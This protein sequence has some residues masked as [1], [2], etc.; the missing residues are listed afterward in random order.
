MSTAPYVAPDTIV[1]ARL[2]ARASAD[3]R[4]RCGLAEPLP[5]REGHGGE[6]GGSPC[7]E[8]ATREQWAGDS[9]LPLD[10]FSDHLRRV[11]PDQGTG[12][13]VV[14]HDRSGRDDRPVADG[15]ALQDGRPRPYPDAVTDGDGRRCSASVDSVVV[16]VGDEDIPGDRTLLANCD[17]VLAG[18]L[19]APVHVCTVPDADDGSRA[20]QVEMHPLVEPDPPP[21]SQ[22]CSGGWTVHADPAKQFCPSSSFYVVSEVERPTACEADHPSPIHGEQASRSTQRTCGNG[23]VVVITAG[24]GRYRPLTPYSGAN[25]CP[26]AQ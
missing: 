4:E 5:S 17:R 10:A 21:E 7:D 2:R 11:P 13:D 18:D 20:V 9:D 12:G 24:L 19:G 26:F 15:D 16:G 14:A 3:Q 22:A 1:D 23:R 6:S 8:G 25:S